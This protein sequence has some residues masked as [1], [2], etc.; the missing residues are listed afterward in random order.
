MFYWAEADT[1][2]TTTGTHTYQHTFSTVHGCDSV[3]T[4]KVTINGTPY[5][6]TL[7]V[8]A[9][10]GYRVIMINRNQI[11]DMPG[12]ADLDSLDLDHP[13]YVT[14]YQ[15]LGATPDITTDKKVATG[16]Y[17]TL[18]NGEPLPAGNQY[19]AYIDIP[20]SVG[21]TC[22]SIGITE[23]ITIGSPAAAPALV[24]SLAKPGEDIQVINLDPTVETL[25]RIYTAEGLLQKTYKAY[26]DTS[27]T[28]KAA[29]D[30]GF[31][32]VELSNESLKSTL[33]YIVK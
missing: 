3:V 12:W 9:Y 30:F 7:E 21:A 8:K 24:P 32:L 2:I 11:N 4:I 14:W 5:V 18:P 15:M 33:R 31:Y 19:Y 27:F 23:V 25:I 13:E 22:G 1:T 26:G 20:A 6:D 16:Y 17:Y 29:G 28:I 10:Y